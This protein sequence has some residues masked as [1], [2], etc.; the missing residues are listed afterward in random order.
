MLPAR[1]QPKQI[2]RYQILEPMAAS[3]KVRAYHAVDQEYRRSVVLKTVAKDP[4]DSDAARDVARF[5]KESE[6]GPRLRHPGIVEVFE[7]GE[8]SGIAYLATEFVEGCTLQSRLRVPIADSGS[9]MIQLLSALEYAHSRGVLHLNV[10]PTHLVL[11]SKGQIKLTDFGGPS[12]GE[13]NS[14]YRSPEQ[15]SGGRIDARSDLFSAGVFFYELLTS[16][17]AFPGPIEELTEQICRRPEIAVSRVKQGVPSVFDQVC[18]KA[19]AKSPKERYATARDFCD[20]VR[21]AYEQEF[22]APPKD[23]VSNETAVSAFLSS[24]RSESKKARTKQPFAKPEPKQAAPPT[25]SN[26][27]P[28]VLRTVEKALAPFLGPLARIVIKEAACKVTDINS[29]YE[30]AAESLSNADR[31]AFLGKHSGTP[32]AE[33]ASG[34]SSDSIET[35]TATFLELPQSEPPRESSPPKVVQPSDAARVEVKTPP[36]PKEV[37]AEKPVRSHVADA[38][39]AIPQRPKVEI[40]K[41]E[42]LHKDPAA[43]PPKP[44]PQADIVAR[45]EDLLGK[46]PENLAGYLAE[47]PPELEQVIHAFIASVDALIRLYDGNGMTFGLTPQSIVFDRMGSASIQ[48]SSATSAGR[49]MLG[50]PMGSPRYAAPEILADAAGAQDTSPV[51]ADIYALGMMFYEILL[52]RKLFRAA[53]PNKTELDWLRWHADASKKAPALKTQLPDPS[54]PLSDL[55]ESMLEKDVAKRAKD[56]ALILM[57]LKSIAQQASRTVVRPRPGRASATKPGA[58]ENISSPR[59][60]TRPS[61]LTIAVVI[62][63]A[64]LLLVAAGVIALRFKNLKLWPPHDATGEVLVTGGNSAMRA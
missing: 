34:I 36:P 27:S 23:L 50:S 59:Q 64:I 40:V 62:I 22:G 30:L 53:V 13:R 58:E 56:P 61:A 17:P 33:S 37:P 2:G 47:E 49:T 21:A 24:L 9:V 46:Q 51:A 54:T 38:T 15:I 43:P 57:R 60:R 5:K 63:T 41:S 42:N 3:G 4:K 26:F 7:Y 39:P 14:P 35:A 45:L 12:E 11:T 1:S 32:Q 18:G 48:T 31:A 10:S 55:L 25:K 44:K 29:L 16:T 52:G 19:L 20:R 8:E 28:D 6:L